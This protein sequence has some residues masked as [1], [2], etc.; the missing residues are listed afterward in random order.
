[1]IAVEFL[2]CF[3]GAFKMAD[4]DIWTVE[5]AIKL[6]IIHVY[7]FTVKAEPEVCKANFVDRIG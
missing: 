5:G 7:G 4:K 2:D 6:P 1:M 3:I